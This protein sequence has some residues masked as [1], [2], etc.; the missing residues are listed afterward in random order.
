MIKQDRAA[1]TSQENLAQAS[2]SSERLDFLLTVDDQWRKEGHILVRLQGFNRT[3]TDLSGLCSFILV[4]ESHSQSQ[5]D[6]NRFSG[7]IHVQKDASEP[8]RGPTPSKLEAG[9]QIDLSVDL[10]K[11]KW[12]RVVQ[13]VWPADDLSVAVPAGNYQ[14]HFE[15]SIKD[16]ETIRIV[17]SNELKV[18]LK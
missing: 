7:P 5:E 4:G 1:T 3:K 13:A 9:Q 18:S 15:I 14:L 16:G 17:K 6:W 12:G 11:L 2:A 8:T 10:T